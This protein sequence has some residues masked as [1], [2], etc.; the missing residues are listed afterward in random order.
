MQ[1]GAQLHSTCKEDKNNGQLP[2]GA[3][4]RRVIG[5]AT[6][7]T[8]LIL[9]ALLDVALGSMLNGLWVSLFPFFAEPPSFALG[10]V[11]ESPEI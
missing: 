5:T 9:A 7:D 2:T 11:L 8:L 3:C 4:S 1:M 10:T 6:S